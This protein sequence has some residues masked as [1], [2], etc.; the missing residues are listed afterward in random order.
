MR[1][2]SAGFYAF[3]RDFP[4]FSAQIRAVFTRF[5]AFLRVGPNFNHGWTDE[6]EFRRWTEMNRSERAAAGRG[7]I[8]A[9]RGSSADLCVTK[10]GLFR[11][12]T[13]S[14]TKVRTD[15]GRKSSMLRIVTGQSLFNHG[16]M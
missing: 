13:R 10:F 3:F 15:Q 2:K 4:R 5:Y 9:L 12:V 7:D 14:F 1:K 16:W 11:D 8:A 6:H